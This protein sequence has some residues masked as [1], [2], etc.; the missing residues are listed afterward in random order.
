MSF[1][2]IQI[3]SGKC[4]RFF[5]KESLCNICEEICPKNAIK[6]SQTPTISLNS[7]I[8]CGACLNCPNEA[9]SLD[10]FSESKLF[11]DMVN[12]EENILSCKKNIPCLGALSTEFLIS[13]QSAKKELILDIGHCS[14]CE[15]GTLFTKIIQKVDEANIVLGGFKQNLITTKD[16]KLNPKES[17]R[18]DFF[19]NFKLNSVAK[20]RNEIDFEVSKALDESFEPK[21]SCESSQKIRAKNLT[22]RR[23]LLFITTKELKDVENIEFNELSFISNKAIS[24]SCDNCGICY[25]ICPTSALSSDMRY[26]KIMFSF[27]LCIKCHLCHDVCKSNSIELNS[28]K[29]R[30]FIT[31]KEQEL[32]KFSIKSCNECGNDFTYLGGEM[33]CQRCKIEED[34]ANELWDL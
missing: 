26:S 4:L 7:C 11:F 20:T 18:R 25:R 12:S 33:I 28:F 21:I 30:D 22:N 34:E 24:N 9:I 29:I 27:M 13:L 14:E 6:I 19:K 2:K 23:K 31:Q 15:I 10:S 17:N 16:I 1:S 32:I 8:E 5:S 3:D